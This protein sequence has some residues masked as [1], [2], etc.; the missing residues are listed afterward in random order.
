MSGNKGRELMVRADDGVLV[1]VSGQSESP[2][3]APEPLQGDAGERV[4]EV[5]NR[6]LDSPGPGRERNLPRSK[7]TALF[8]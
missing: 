4:R 5:Q 3:S 7:T 6:G 8:H 2:F 1:H